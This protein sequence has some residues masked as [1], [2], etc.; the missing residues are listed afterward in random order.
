MSISGGPVFESLSVQTL[1]SMPPSF[2]P[3]PKIQLV[4]QPAEELRRQ[5][6]E[7]APVNASHLLAVLGEV[8]DIALIEIRCRVV[9]NVLALEQTIQCD[10]PTAE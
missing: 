5:P 4:T 1:T 2:V 9:G 3:I 10:T 6:L 8:I 7:V